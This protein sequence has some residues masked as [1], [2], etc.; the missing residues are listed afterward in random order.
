MI[1]RLLNEGGNAVEGVS[2]IN[3]ENV[4]KT[5]KSFY[6]KVLPVLRITKNDTA[7]LGSTGKK[8]PGGSSGDIDIAVSRPA[9]VK[10]G[11]GIADS[12]IFAYVVHCAKKLGVSF[13]PMPGLGIVSIA[14]PIENVDGKQEGKTVQVDL[15][16]TDNLNMT[17]WG[18]Y[19]AH[20]KEQPYK[21]AVRNLILYW[22]ANVVDYKALKRESD[23]DTEFEKDLFDTQRGLFRL[24]QSYYDDKGKLSNKKKT[25]FR[26]LIS[27]DPDAI[28]KI[29]L[30][31]KYKASDILTVNAAWD[32]LMSPDFPYKDYRKT[33]V[34]NIVNDL[35]KHN[36]DYP[37][38][39]DKYIDNKS[40]VTEAYSMLLEAKNTDYDTP[41]VGMTK[42][43][44]MNPQQFVNFIN[45]LKMLL[46]SKS[47]TKINLADLN[48]QEKVDG[49]GVRVVVN[50][51]A[52]G[53]ESSYS[54]VVY[55]ADEFP[56]EQFR[57]TLS[58][59]QNVLGDKLIDIA[60][61]YK[62]NY[63]VIGELFYIN[64]VN[65]IDADS[66][67]TF[68][69]T[70]YDSKK[71]GSFG[72]I[73]IFN[74]DGI[75][76]NQLVPLSL[77]QRKGIINDLK[78]LTTDQFKFFSDDD[79]KW[80]GEF[81]IQV[82]YDTKLGKKILNNPELLL[83]KSNKDFFESFRD[84][85]A[86]AF[87]REISKK[88]SLF[89]V[90]ET[91]VEGI[92]FDVNGQKFGATNFNWKEKKAAI[93][94]SEE[95]FN[96]VIADFYK[97]VFGFVKPKKI[98]QLLNTPDYKKLYGVPYKNEVAQFKQDLKAAKYKF[99]HDKLIPAAIKKMQRFFVEE[100]WQ[101]LKGINTNIDSLK[102]ALQ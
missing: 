46:K 97:K 47:N 63:K 9:L 30:G 88:G 53:L 89:G 87:S 79:I 6:S 60:S 38:Y 90:P 21:G 28:I 80:K 64:D 23:K 5:L 16:L 15:M 61:K 84:A 82:K 1:I 35:K 34:K 85:I 101:K 8:L 22:I 40:M 58:Y 95:E 96:Q 20:E 17:K 76:N 32:A 33:I 18:M 59:L 55:N 31:D 74:A 50:N 36:L 62:I 91:E 52:I 44:Q 10:N 49:T 73:I 69:G 67:V 13:K 42:I 72:S 4:A 77:E 54:G 70:K 71:L 27:D 93:Y 29:L 56:L 86:Q 11:L 51:G 78:G 100:T 3:Q 19:S 2:R 99:D 41:R 24:K 57:E 37:A 75:Q 45:T 12:D 92:V 68:I 7:V 94:K 65:S 14:W 26:K 81:D 66:T 43:H 102:K 25:I 39:I 98:Q 83:D 48:V